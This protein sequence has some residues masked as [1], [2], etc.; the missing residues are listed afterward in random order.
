MKR[1]KKTLTVDAAR[2]ENYPDNEVEILFECNRPIEFS[3]EFMLK[4][5]HLVMD[6]LIIDGKNGQAN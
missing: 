2:T 1:F 5:T 4:L 6:E 3:Q